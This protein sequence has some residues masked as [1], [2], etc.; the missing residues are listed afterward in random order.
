M[1][2]PV[3]SPQDWN[4]WMSQ[5][6]I[7]GSLEIMKTPISNQ[8]ALFEKMNLGAIYMM[9]GGLSPLVPKEELR[10][11]EDILGPSIDIGCAHVWWYS[12]DISPPQEIDGNAYRQRNSMEPYELPLFMKPIFFRESMK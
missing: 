12:K 10:R 11:L 9:D 8:E 5:H 2:L 4:S 1:V 6:S 3:G 7:I